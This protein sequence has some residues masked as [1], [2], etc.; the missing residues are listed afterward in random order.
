MENTSRNY[1][2]TG[3]AC[4]NKLGFLFSKNVSGQNVAHGKQIIHFLGLFSQAQFFYFSCSF[5]QLPTAT[6]GP[7][8]NIRVTRRV[9]EKVAQN[10]TQTVVC[11]NKKYHIRRKSVAKI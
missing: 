3:S 4:N 9:C 5:L 8:M 1:N 6:S 10:V 2:T 7:F 11:Q